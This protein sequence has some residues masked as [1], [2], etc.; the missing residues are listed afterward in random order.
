M[1]FEVGNSYAVGKG[2]PRGSKN[3][4]AAQVFT[5]AL[6][7]WQ[8]PVRDDS[9]PE[10]K[11]QAAL[12]YLSRYKP[13]EWVK[14]TLSILPRDF[15]VEHVLADYRQEEVELMIQELSKQIVAEQQS[16]PLIEHEKVPVDVKRSTP[17]AA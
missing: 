10:T 16:P 13:L 7:I 2:R 6:A 3:K 14:A 5:D 15:A 4:L 17:S 9:P 8:R 1:K 12:L 11:G